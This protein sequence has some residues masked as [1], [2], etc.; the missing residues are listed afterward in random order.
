MEQEII[1]QPFF[2]RENPEQMIY[3]RLNYIKKTKED[4]PSKKYIY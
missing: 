4:W 1:V 2:Y 3:E